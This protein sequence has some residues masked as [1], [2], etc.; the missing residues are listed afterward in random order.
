MYNASLWWCRTA[1]IPVLGGGERRILGAHWL[2]NVTK[3][4]VPASVRD[5]VWKDKVENDRGRN[6]TST[7]MGTYIS[8]YI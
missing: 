8:T 4:W 2:G 3:Q 5:T 1:V 7:H 6:Q